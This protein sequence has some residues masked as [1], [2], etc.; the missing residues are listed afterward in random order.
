MISDYLHGDSGA[1]QAEGIHTTVPSSLGFF[2]LTP[3]S[4]REGDD[5]SDDPAENFKTIT[6]VSPLWLPPPLAS[7]FLKTSVWNVSITVT[8]TGS[9]PDFISGTF[10]YDIIAGTTKELTIESG[11]TI[12]DEVV[13]EPGWI[14]GR[15][16][17]ESYGGTFGGL[18]LII[19][20]PTGEEF[21][22]FFS[23][24]HLQVAVSLGRW[25]PANRSTRPPDV[26]GAKPRW[27]NREGL[28]EVWIWD[29]GVS[30][31]VGYFG[32]AGSSY[33]IFSTSVLNYEGEKSGYVN[34]P[35]DDA[36]NA[37]LQVTVSHGAFFEEF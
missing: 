33:P 22:P 25:K 7:K 14:I 10:D 1:Q 15:E 23:F 11:V 3:D 17:V 6:R 9:E 5:P 27:N 35:F 31:V 16:A 8:P 36:D 24:Y 12:K 18:N 21:N 2:T 32:F 4:Y 26:G 37:H 13:N 30:A 20:E 19:T 29:L 28:D 34:P